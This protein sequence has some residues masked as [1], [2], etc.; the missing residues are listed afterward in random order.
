MRRRML[1]AVRTALS[2]FALAACGASSPYDASW[3]SAEVGK[4]AGHAVPVRKAGGQRAG[5]RFLPTFP[6]GLTSAH[7]L[8]EDDA[9]SVALWNSAQF[10]A[11]LAQL[12]FS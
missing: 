8:S 5:G 4:T 9:V 10:R 3:V 1:D 7:S 12:G 2:V 6:A 11:D